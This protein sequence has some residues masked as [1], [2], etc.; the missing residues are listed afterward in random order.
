MKPFFTKD[1][2]DIEGRPTTFTEAISLEKANALLSER[3]RVV[4]GSIDDGGLIYFG[5]DEHDLD[6]HTA[7]L[8]NIEPIN[9]DNAGKL[10]KDLGSF[11]DFPKDETMWDLIERAKALL[12]E[13]TK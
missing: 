3:G 8:I 5:T 2:C 6:T 11:E 9:Q 10:I 1:D 7:L 12:R 13:G 4:T